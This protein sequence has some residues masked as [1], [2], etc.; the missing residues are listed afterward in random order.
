M[1]APQPATKVDFS[2]CQSTVVGELSLGAS[3]GVVTVVFSP[4]SVFV[5][6]TVRPVL[7]AAS[8]SVAPSACWAWASATAFCASSWAALRASSSAAA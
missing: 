8:A 2:L 3:A 7:S 1:R 5:F 6:S 4:V